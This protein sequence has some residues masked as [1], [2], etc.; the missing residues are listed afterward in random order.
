VTTFSVLVVDDEPSLR[1]LLVLL[2]ERDPRFTV[3]GQAGD[4][5]AAL[6]EVDRLDP[7]LLLLDLGLPGRDGLEVLQALEA[8]PR[9]TTV[10]LTGFTDPATHDRARSLGAADC[11]VKGA[12]PAELLERLGGAAG[13]RATGP[14]A[15]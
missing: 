5:D 4:G 15:G 3:V 6:A 12:D 7:D 2:L 8:R 10:V 14:E 9:P 13:G 11:I 1:R